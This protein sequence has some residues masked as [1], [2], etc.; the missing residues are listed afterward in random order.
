MSNN[1]NTS[2]KSNDWA[3]YKNS[4]NENI[5]FVMNPFKKSYYPIKDE[6]FPFIKAK[7]TEWP[8]A[9]GDFMSSN[10]R[11]VIRLKNKFNNSEIVFDVTDLNNPR[12]YRYSLQR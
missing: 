11:G 9:W 6:R 1:K 7:L 5:R 12:R 8:H 3:N 2:F 4:E 10:G